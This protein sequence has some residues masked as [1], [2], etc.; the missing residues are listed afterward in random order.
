[1]FGS[2]DEFIDGSSKTAELKTY[3]IE[4]EFQPVSPISKYSRKKVLQIRRK[5]T[6][7]GVDSYKASDKSLLFKKFAENYP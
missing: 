1:M 3:E 6:M 4:D 2:L 7:S 5:R